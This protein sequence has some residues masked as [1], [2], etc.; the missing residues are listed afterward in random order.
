MT[1]IA[2]SIGSS[3]V[4][5]TATKGWMMYYAA[6]FEV[7]GSLDSTPLRSLISKMV[8]PDEYGKVFTFM[9]TASAIAGL[10]TSSAYQE[11]YSATL[12]FYPGT[13]YLVVSGMLTIA[14]VMIF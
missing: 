13:L 10:V 3:A 9:A 5:G 11:I 8:E 2:V 4:I 14:L 6:S 12:D 7:L 1:G